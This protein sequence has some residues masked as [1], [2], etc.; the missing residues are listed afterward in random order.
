MRI[1]IY[2][3]IYVYIYIYIHMFTF[4]RL[5]AIT[6]PNPKTGEIKVEY[7]F[8][9]P[10]MHKALYDLTPSSIKK[11]IHLSIA[12]VSILYKFAC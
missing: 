5:K 8:T 12:Q 4:I 10:L 3:Y 6:H 11:T 7:D 1:C 2:M 9:H